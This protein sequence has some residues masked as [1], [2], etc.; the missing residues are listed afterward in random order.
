MAPRG[1][2]FPYL[3]S[4]KIPSHG[5][6]LPGRKG[7]PDR[8]AACAKAQRWESPGSSRKWQHTQQGPGGGGGR[9]SQR[10]LMAVPG[11]EAVG[12]ASSQAHLPSHLTSI[13]LSVPLPQVKPQPSCLDAG[14][15]LPT[16][17]PASRVHVGTAEPP[18]SGPTLPAP[19]ARV[20]HRHLPDPFLFL[21]HSEPLLTLF[22]PLCEPFLDNCANQ[23]LTNLPA[24]L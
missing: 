18:R 12:A 1:P 11:E 3:E 19:L 10:A 17:P 21:P 24:H 2:L 16:S 6:G 7:A 8:G 13:T 22:P 9:T 14:S 23:P 4:S 15:Q 20:K 5:P